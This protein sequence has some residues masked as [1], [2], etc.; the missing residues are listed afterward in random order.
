MKTKIEFGKIKPV[1]QGTGFYRMLTIIETDRV[2][3]E[4]IIISGSIFAETVEELE[5][6]DFENFPE[7]EDLD[8]NR[9]IKNSMKDNG[10]RELIIHGEA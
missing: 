7:A 10:S 1:I 9:H 6:I 3:S 8:I 2:S 5:V 4:Q